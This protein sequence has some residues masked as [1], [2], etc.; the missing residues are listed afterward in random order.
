[1]AK[2]TVTYTVT[3]NLSNKSSTG[4][5]YQEWLDEDKDTK[6]TRKW[7]AIDRFIG[8][9]NLELFDKKAK[10]TVSEEN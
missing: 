5:E 10:L 8:H 1:M 9:H 6:S 3:Y 4:R 7:F 2:V